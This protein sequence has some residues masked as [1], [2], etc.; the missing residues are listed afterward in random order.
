MFRFHLKLLAAGVATWLGFWLAGLP[1]YYQQYP[2]LWIG[3]GTV[4]LA[5]G[6]AWVG[7]RIISRAK[8]ERRFS[9]AFWLSFYFTVPFAALDTA[10]CAL[11]LGHGHD[12]LWRFWYLTV[13][14]PLPWLL[15]LPMVRLA[16]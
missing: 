12:Y 13:F 14:Y 16:R 10:Y 3:I 15:Y 8:P 5:I 7:W 2:T 9:T 6:T 11:Y 1:D 4:F